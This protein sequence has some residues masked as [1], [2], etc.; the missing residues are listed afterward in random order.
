MQQEN[1][2]ENTRYLLESLALASH[3]MGEALETTAAINEG[4]RAEALRLVMVILRE[5]RVSLLAV[6]KAEGMIMLLT[7]DVA[8]VNVC[9]LCGKTLDA[10]DTTDGKC[11]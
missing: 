9:E 4:E 10:H 1:S 8:D 7:P 6:S 3:N 5:M 2:T 11:L